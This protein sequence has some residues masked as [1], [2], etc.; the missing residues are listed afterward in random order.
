M[1]DADGVPVLLC[2]CNTTAPLVFLNAFVTIADP[3]DQLTVSP[4]EKLTAAFCRVELISNVGLLPFKLITAPD[5]DEAEPPVLI[6][7]SAGSA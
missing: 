5:P 2:I 3:P 6:T 4:I 1:C 7:M